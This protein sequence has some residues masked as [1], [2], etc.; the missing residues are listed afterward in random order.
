MNR[1]VSGLLACA[2]LLTGTIDGRPTVAA[3]LLP[4]LGIDLQQTSVSGISSG[5]YMAGQYHLAH[6]SYVIGAGIIAGGPF[7]CAAST[8]AELSLPGLAG[9]AN[10]GQAFNGCM[11]DLMQIWGI[12]NPTHLAA[13]AE[14]LAESGRIDPLVHARKG[15]IY[16]FSGRDDVIVRPTI[17]A[18]AAEFYIT[19]G[20]PAAQIEHVTALAAGHAFVTESKGG[21]CG[22]SGPPFIVSCNYDQAGRMLTHIYSGGLVAP[23]EGAATGRMRSFDQA[24][25]VTGLA[26]HG[27]ADMGTIYVPVSCEASLGCRTHV[28]FHGCAQN[29]QA[30]GTAFIEDTGFLRWADTNRIVLLFPEVRS[31]LVNPQACWD[32]WG[33]TGADFLTRNAPQIEAVHRMLTELARR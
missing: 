14:Q 33:Y 21:A 28:A 13:R 15:R 24:P 17:V 10:A 3:D 2:A 22:R 19:L 12:P 30:V 4:R 26:G 1:I 27:L 8:F 25:F 9:A 29:R 23:G 7:G 18:A 31:S 32:W 20:V 11:L 6:A 5:A 16:L